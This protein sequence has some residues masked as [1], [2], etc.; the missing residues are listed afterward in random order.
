MVFFSHKLTVHLSKLRILIFTL[1]TC[2]F[3]S[4]FHFKFV[5]TDH[6]CVTIATTD[7]TEAKMATSLSV[8]GFTSTLKGTFTFLK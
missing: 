2:C 8:E 6:M 7:E 5:L 1:A 3:I 4:I